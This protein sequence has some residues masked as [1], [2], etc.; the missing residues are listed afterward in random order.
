MLEIYEIPVTPFMQNCTLLVCTE[1]QDAAVCDCGDAA[2]VL[3]KIKQLGVKVSK[4]I[5]THGHLDHIGGTA[6]L[7][8]ALQIPFW[9][10]R[11]DDFLR[12]GLVEQ[13]R[14]YGFP[15]VSVPEVNIDI[16]P[17]MDLTIGNCPLEVL[18]CP[19]HTPGHVVFH[20]PIGNQIIAGD[21]LFQ[22]SIG[23]TDFP[24]SNPEDL[25]RSIQT[26]LYTLAP[27]TVVHC[28][29]GPTTT[30][31]EEARSNPFVRAI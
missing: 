19:G 22:G 3:Q 12:E 20:D 11:G 2:P 23:R 25:L 7:M 13:A 21:V 17:G 4:V 26:Q 8:Q 5:A 28:G 6:D 24:F 31:G 1:T 29:H 14:M 18:P 30:I 15:S 9:F 16:L 10:P 27:E